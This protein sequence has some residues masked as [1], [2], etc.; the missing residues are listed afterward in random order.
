LHVAAI[1]RGFRRPA[2]QI[3]GRSCY[4]RGHVRDGVLWPS[5][6]NIFGEH[7]HWRTLF[8]PCTANE[9]EHTPLGVFGVRLG[10]RLRRNPNMV[11]P[12]SDLSVCIQTID[13]PM[14]CCL[15]RS[16]ATRR[17]AAPVGLLS[18]HINCD[19]PRARRNVT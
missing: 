6:A 11:V 16:L 17:N 5:Q 1:E 19:G 13:S 15:L 12:N 9:H 2:G 4:L 7:E 10:V 14:E 3:A 8:A 18:P